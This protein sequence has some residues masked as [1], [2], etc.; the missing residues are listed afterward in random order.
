M[1]VSETIR[2]SATSMRRVSEIASS[3]PRSWVTR[4]SVPGIVLERRLELLDGRQVEVVRRLVE[5]Q[6]VHALGAEQRERRP[7]PF[8]GRQ[9]IRGPGDVLGSEPEL[10]EQRTGLVA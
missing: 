6:A 1:G 9:R 8:A 7:R 4:S 2:P 5:D 3:R 10:G